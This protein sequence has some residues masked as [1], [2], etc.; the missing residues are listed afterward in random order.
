LS[1]TEQSQL[2]KEIGQILLKEERIPF[3]NSTFL[4]SFNAFDTR[5]FNEAVI[6]INAAF[7]GYVA[8]FLILKLMKKGYSEEDVQKD[9]GRRF[10]R[11]KAL[12]KVLTSDF[13]EIIGKSLKDDDK[14]LWEKFEDA[15]KKRKTAVNPYI[16][17]LTENDAFKAISDILE[18][19]NWIKK[20]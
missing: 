11:P 6:L 19:I 16:S 20:Q 12:H 13:K 9:V 2:K 14:D 15:R 8:D 1:I 17:Q 18:I 3:F 10:S 4:D 7:E 5:R